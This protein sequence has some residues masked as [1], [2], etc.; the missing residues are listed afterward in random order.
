MHKR[1]GLKGVVRVAMLTRSK[2]RMIAY[3]LRKR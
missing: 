1:S 2:A 3:G